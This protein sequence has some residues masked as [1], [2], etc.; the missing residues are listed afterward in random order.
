MSL[1]G[2]HFSSIVPRWSFP[3]QNTD[4]RNRN[5]SRSGWNWTLNE[6][7][8]TL[9][10][11]SLLSAPHELLE[12]LLCAQSSSC[13]GRHEADRDS[14][15]PKINKS[16]VIRLIVKVGASQFKFASVLSN[17]IPHTC[18]LP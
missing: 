13:M 11:I 8:L 6:A 1:C 16:N 4:L 9:C 18:K 17:I 14:K 7:V 5:V 15:R 12:L 3:P 10:L 2:G